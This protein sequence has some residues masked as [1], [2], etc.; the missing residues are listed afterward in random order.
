[1]KYFVVLFFCLTT[2]IYAQNIYDTNTNNETNISTTQIEKIQS[3]F[4]SYE[5][6]P[7]KVYVG[8]LFAVKVKAIIANDN[9]EDI[10]SS[11]HDSQNIEILNPHSKW[12]WFSDNI[13]YN[14]FYMKATN[15]DTKLP[16]LKLNIYQNSKQIDSG[17]LEPATPDVIKL[18]GTKYFSGVIAKKLEIKKNKI[19]HFDDK[20]LIVVLEIEAQQANLK[21]FE[22]KWVDRDGID[23]SSENLPFFKIFYYAIIPEF[24]K[25]FTF[26]Y[27]N[28][29]TNKFEKISIPV[30][31]ADDKISTQIDLNPAQSS[32]QIYKDGAYL[33]IALLLIGLFI[34]RRKITYV[35]LLILLIALL[36][37]DKNPLNSVKIDKNSKIKILPTPK[38]T[39]FYVTDRTLYAQ[40]LDSRDNYIKILLPNGKIGWINDGKN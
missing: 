7:S 24:T 10:S 14:T 31:V 22:L 9:F 27:F 5:E 29:D 2:F 1:M 37:Y 8:E 35:I 18:N 36:I 6:S 25:E 21:D 17:E 16:V 12:Q 26:T 19:T 38:S 40:K 11:F 30:V 20:S 15:V 28:S 3:I 32:L 4:L 33:F 34:R 13:F 39:V 23:S